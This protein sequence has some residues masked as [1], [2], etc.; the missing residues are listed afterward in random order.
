MDENLEKAIKKILKHLDLPHTLDCYE[1][2]KEGS[3][4]NTEIVMVAFHI[5]HEDFQAHFDEIDAA[6]EELGD[7]FG[8]PV[9]WEDQTIVIK[10]E[11]WDEESDIQHERKDAQTEYVYHP[12]GALY[13][14][15]YLDQ[16]EHNGV[17]I[18]LLHEWIK[19]P[20]AQPFNRECKECEFVESLSTIVG[21]ELLEEF[22]FDLDMALTGLGYELPYLVVTCPYVD[23][24]PDN[25]FAMLVLCFNLDQFDGVPVK[26]KAEVEDVASKVIAQW[27]GIYH[28]GV[29]MML[30]DSDGAFIQGG[31]GG[32]I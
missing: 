22:R 12:N 8:Y 13:V 27:G 28:W 26:W 4:S 25:P 18:H 5:D 32:N 6:F 3:E 16:Q 15:F 31:L 10:V 24:L 11:K 9:Y 1:E 21:T 23:F 19:D 14:R 7:E 29:P 20:T 2:N 17:F 30:H